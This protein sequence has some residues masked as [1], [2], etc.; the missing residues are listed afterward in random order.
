M[1]KTILKL[2]KNLYISD[3]IDKI[4]V[5]PYHSMEKFDIY[6]KRG[7]IFVRRFNYDNLYGKYVFIDKTGE[8]YFYA[9]DYNPKNW[10][11]E[12]KGD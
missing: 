3:I 10:F 9:N 8:K 6:A 2:K 5:S 4:F 12:D 11:I 7:E 1:A